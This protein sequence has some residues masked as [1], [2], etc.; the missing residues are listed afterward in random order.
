MDALTKLA[1]NLESFDPTIGRR[2]AMTLS[3]RDADRIAK[4]RDAG[5]VREEH[6]QRVQVM[7]N[8]VLVEAGAYY[9]DWMEEIIRCLRGHHEPQEEVVFDEIVR[10]LAV[11]QTRATMI[12]FGSFWTYYGLWFCRT[13]PQARAIAVE[14]DPAYL[15]VGRRN[16]ALNGLDGA[17]KFR[18]GAIGDEPGQHLPFV[19][20]SDGKTYT[21][22][23]CDLGSIL[24]TE[25]LD[26]VDLVLADVQGAETTLLRRAADLLRAGKVR[27]LIVSTHHHSISGDALTH[28][29]ALRM[30]TELGAHVVCE[31]GVSESYS[32]DGLIAVS[33]Q[34]RDRDLVVE[35]SRARSKDSLFGELEYD[36][37]DCDRQLHRAAADIAL[38]R[39]ELGCAGA[40]LAAAVNDANA[41]RVRL[42][43]VESDRDA[44][45]AQLDGI[46]ATKLWRWSRD[47]R[48]LYGRLRR[49]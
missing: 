38:M 7:H 15:E 6:G 5:T 28:Q 46:Y 18:H 21:V 47:L 14:P 20:E 26:R 49:A 13:I 41:L 27:F 44:C 48:A 9:G 16:A 32:G 30:L 31:H 36:V 45:H 42:T 12:E 22:E 43:E 19:A 17:V 4:V 29:G 2:V 39:G 24:S 23:Q 11:D 40:E 37:A 35:V 1:P 25:G 33:F 3:C 10:R 8:G 34:K